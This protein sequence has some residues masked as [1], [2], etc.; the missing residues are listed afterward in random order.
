MQIYIAPEIQFIVLY[1]QLKIKTNS[2]IKISIL[3]IKK[4]TGSKVRMM[5]ALW[6][7]GFFL[8]AECMHACG[9]MEDPY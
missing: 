8:G 3:L 1:S 5:A 9:A 7:A 4:I 2:T 6:R